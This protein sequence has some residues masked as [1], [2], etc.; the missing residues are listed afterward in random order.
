[1]VCTHKVW[2]CD[3]RND[4]CLFMVR[5]LICDTGENNRHRKRVAPGSG[6]PP[7]PPPP[8]FFVDISNG[9]GQIECFSPIGSV[10]VVLQY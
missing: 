5:M 8:K 1:M 10:Q 4:G 6:A 9:A 3:Y 7:P 2:T